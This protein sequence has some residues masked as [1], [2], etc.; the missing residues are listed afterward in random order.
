MILVDTN[1]IMYATGQEHPSKPLCLALLERVATGELDVAIDT[2]ALQEIM[3]RY[4]NMGRWETGGREAF[5]ITC[6]LFVTILP[7]TDQVAILGARLLDEHR[8]MAAR[9]A[10]H[11][12][13]VLVNDLDGICSFDRDFDCIQT[14]RRYVPDA[15]GELVA[16]Q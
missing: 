15:Q 2:E 1:V 16:V 11:A 6:A 5:D 9:D 14:V 7:V 8:A 3:H 13:A 10:I 4:R 12:A